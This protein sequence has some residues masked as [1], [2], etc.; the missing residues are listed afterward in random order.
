MKIS[1][2]E[3][4]PPNLTVYDQALLPR[5]G[6]PL[7]G[8]ILGDAGHEVRIYVEMLAPVDWADVLCSDLVGFSTTTAT[9]PA[10]YR[11]AER[12]RT[13]PTL[14]TVIGGSHVT[15]L[16]DEGL[17]HC[18]FVV[19]G[20]GHAAILELVSAMRRERPYESI[21]G[22][23]YHDPAGTKRHNA[24]RPFC[25]QEELAALPPPDLSLIVG[26]ERM[27]NVPIMTQWGCPF[28]CDFCSVIK[29]F[30]R[31][32]RA[33]NVD[34]VLDELEQYRDRDSVFFYDDN[35]I[36]NKQ[37]TARLLTGMLERRLDLRWSAQIRADSVYKNKRMREID[38]DFLT[39]M[40]R[41]GAQMVYCGFES[42]NPATLRTYNK[43]Q[44]VETIR[45]AIRAL[46]QYGIAVHGMFVLGSDADDMRTFEETTAFALRNRIDT[47]QLMMLTPCPG[48]D[49]FDR[50]T[51]EGRLLSR[52]WS[53]FDGHHCLIRPAQMSAYELQAGTYKAMAKFYLARYSVPILVANIVR[54]LPFVIGLLM[55]YPSLVWRL[56]VR[57]R[58]DDVAGKLRD[59][60]NRRS[61]QRVVDMLFVPTLR[62]YARAHI[63]KWGRQAGLQAHLEFLRSL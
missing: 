26:H 55:R 47:I 48:T 57:P 29:M 42:V 39:L 34:D 13:V 50:I 37:R 33:R 32:V 18:D 9:A 40:Q 1:L 7:L 49:F 8:R 4:K 53:L 25:S 35:F 30:G 10:A 59:V 15:F 3:P 54:N 36:V 14:R 17:D 22:L 16:A 63:R 51:A 2:I 43:E 19:R 6:L 62:F 5:L 31:R 58:S 46:H 41:S 20:E 24:E 61:W 45:D 44:D 21:A 23:S 60:L 38:H 56:L 27:T 28:T 12:C 52:D 11:M